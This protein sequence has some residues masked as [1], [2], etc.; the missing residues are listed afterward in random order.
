VITTLFFQECAL[1]HTSRYIIVSDLVLPG[2]PR[3]ST[4]SD[5]HWGEKTWVQC[6]L[7]KLVSCTLISSRMTKSVLWHNYYLLI[8]IANSLWTICLPLQDTFCIGRPSLV[9][10]PEKGR[11]KGPGFHCLR[12][13]LIIRNRNTYS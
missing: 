12:M 2:V 7:S 9:P 11:R 13:R 1:L 8:G 6:Y 5:K 10:R 3:I 4:A